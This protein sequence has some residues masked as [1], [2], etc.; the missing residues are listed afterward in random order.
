MHL[1]KNVVW[2]S[3]GYTHVCVLT[4][5]ENEDQGCFGDNT[6]GQAEVPYLL[7]YDIEKIEHFSAG[8]QITCIL[9][10]IGQITC[11]GRNDLGQTDSPREILHQ[12]TLRP[13]QY[14][15]QTGGMHN[16][17]QNGKNKI[18]CWGQND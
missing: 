4:M 14:E 7:T 16:C 3:V 15:V 18:D 9:H 13:L 2:Y 5:G 17:A 10:S 8:C 1:N 11:V 12:Y 6:S